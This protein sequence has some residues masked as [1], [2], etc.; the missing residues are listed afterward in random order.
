M[1][2]TELIPGVK[3]LSYDDKILLLNLVTGELVKDAGLASVTPQV[4]V[5]A[6]SGLHD[7]YEAAA[8]LAQFLADHQA[9][10]K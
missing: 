6:G 2:L 8:V 1:T 7:S 9:A 3:S 4:P 10:N 5:T